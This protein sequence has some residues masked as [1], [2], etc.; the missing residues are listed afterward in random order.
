MW[1]ILAFGLAACSHGRLPTPGE[2]FLESPK[3]EAKQCLEESDINPNFS[4]VGVPKPEIAEKGSFNCPQLGC[5]NHQETATYDLVAENVEMI[6]VAI[7][8]PRWKDDVKMV[9]QINIPD[10]LVD[11]NGNQI[12]DRVYRTFCGDWCDLGFPFN[13]TYHCDFLFILRPGEEFKN[14]AHFDIYIRRNT[15]GSYTIPE[16][17]Q[18][19]DGALF[20]AF[21]EEVRARVVA[22]DAACDGEE[23]DFVNFAGSRWIHSPPVGD[24]DPVV[25]VWK[26]NDKREI[27]ASGVRFYDRR[28]Q[29]C[30]VYEAWKNLRFEFPE[31][32]EIAY[33]IEER[34]LAEA[35]ASG[36]PRAIISYKEFRRVTETVPAGKTLQL[37]T[38]EPPRQAGWVVDW[39]TESK[40]AI[41]IYD[42][43]EHELDVKLKTAGRLTV[44]LPEYN[45]ERGWQGVRGQADG[46]VVYQG[47]RYPY[48]YYEAEIE[49]VKV[50][51]EGFVVA[52]AELV[53][54]F[55][56]VLPKF[57]LNQREVFEF[58]DYWMDRLSTDQP[59][60]FIHFL[61]EEEIERI[62]DLEIEGARVESLIRIRT[63]FKPLE[64]REEIVEQ[65]LPD[66]PPQRSGLTVVEWGGFLDN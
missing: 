33:L 20:A 17:L 23:G 62:E 45:K 4:I 25:A 46:T 13:G 65:E 7:D 54:F 60:Y 38:F 18:C 44:S 59:Y 53:R 34:K 1:V 22:E 49:T 5:Q 28:D 56:Q 9:K 39:L 61:N 31:S 24:Q 36:D 47:K 63:Y 64:V 58:V 19:K 51:G 40:P 48:L 14:G 30:G 42:T 11:P 29:S 26:L 52:G 8:D 32:D 37:G 55:Y 3:F 6:K 15:D 10:G 50:G 21:D 35:I 2:R 41:Y 27:L 66:S 57:G 12:K 16:K 43:K